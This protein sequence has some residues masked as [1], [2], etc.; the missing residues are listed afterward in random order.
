VKDV[1]FTLGI[2]D[3]LKF[4]VRIES[5]WQASEAYKKNISVDDF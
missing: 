4:E 2:Y 3:F 5:N 1:T